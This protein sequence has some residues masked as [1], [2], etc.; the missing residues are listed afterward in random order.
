MRLSQ[1]TIR[2]IIVAHNNK[3]ATT[4][5]AARFNV[6]EETVESHITRFVQTYGTTQ[7]VYSL[8]PLAPKP[9]QHPSLK[10]LLCGHARDHIRRR[11]RETITELTQRLEKANAI[12]IRLE[13]DAV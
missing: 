13:Y 7:A 10:C 5:I 2:E 9:C 3:E 11:E 8:I 6:S 1:A 4:I 12:L